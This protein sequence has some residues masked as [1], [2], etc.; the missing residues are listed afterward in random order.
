TNLSETVKWNIIDVYNQGVENYKKIQDFV[1]INDDIPRTR[2]GKIKRYQLPRFLDE[3]GSKEVKEEIPEFEEYA[4]LS[5]HIEDL[6]GK[7][8][9][10][11]NHLEIDLGMDSLSIIELQL[12]IEKTFGMT[13]KD[14]ELAEYPTV[15]SLAETIRERKTKL[16]K[17]SIN[18]KEV[19]GKSGDIILSRKTWVIRLLLVM[20]RLLLGRRIKLSVS[21]TENIPQGPCIIAP[22]HESF[23][24][25]LVLL[26]NL[27][28]R[29]LEDTYFFAKEKNFR[30]PMGRAFASRAH[31][32]I[33][34]INRNL[35]PSLQMIAAVL[36]NGKKIVIYPEG[37][38]SRDGKL[39]PF[40][41]TFALVSSQMEV[42]VVPVAIR[43]TYELLPI[44]KYFPSRGAVTVTFLPAVDP[45]GKDEPAIIAQ[46]RG[47]VESALG[48][49][50]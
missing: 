26:A 31:V 50:A 9:F 32:I 44:G 45:R 10:P 2:M 29:I 40:K 23:L 28:R 36:K 38:R 35:I 49:K 12:R 19:F 14:G 17:E 47:A 7:V 16:N 5:A 21:G 22:N 15:L 27:D 24:D 39:Q 25:T 1:I 3:R 6:C 34:D 43:G 33:M 41:K 8:P 30:V 46:T 13:F 18:W 37:A 11:S 42:P 20:F 48:N 4:A